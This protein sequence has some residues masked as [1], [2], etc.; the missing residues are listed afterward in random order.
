MNFLNPFNYLGVKSRGMTS[1][2]ANLSLDSC[3]GVSEINC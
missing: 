1:V 2:Y 3:I